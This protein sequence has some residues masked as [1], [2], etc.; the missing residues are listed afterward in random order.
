[1]PPKK[2]TLK[3]DASIC[4]ETLHEDAQ[5]LAVAKPFGV[6][7]HPSPGYWEKGTVAHAVVGKVPPEMLEERGNHNEW[8][9]FIPRCIVH[10]L[11]AGTTGVMVLAKCMSAERHLAQQ[12][13]AVDLMYHAPI[14]K[15][16][17]VSLL[18]GHPGG[19]Q[20][21]SD[22]TV[23]GSIG[24]HPKIGRSWAVVPDGKPAKTIIRVHAFSKEHAMSLVTAELR[25][26]F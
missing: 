22:V 16:I 11:D 20:R 23:A 14:G 19:P 13:R 15:K 24:R 26:G 10:R 5:L 12:M 25:H 7:A 21:K 4:L 17:Y 18:L 1:M 2:L 8:D 3:F 6:L 9:S